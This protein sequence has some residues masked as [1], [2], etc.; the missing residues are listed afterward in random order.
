MTRSILSEPKIILADEPTASLDAT[1]SSKIASIFQ[2]LQSPDRIIIIATHED[3]FDL[4]ADEIILL[5]YG[6]IR[7][8][9]KNEEKNAKQ[10]QDGIQDTYMEPKKKAKNNIFWNV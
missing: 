1:N 7:H 3:C 8:V 9:N 5:D 6:V 4:I 10:Q 2:E